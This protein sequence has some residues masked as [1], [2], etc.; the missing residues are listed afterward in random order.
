MYA[1]LWE[2]DHLA[3]CKREEMETALQLERNRAAL[4]VGLLEV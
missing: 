3:K 4:E 1:K 2:R